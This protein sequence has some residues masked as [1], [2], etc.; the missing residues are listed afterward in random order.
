MKYVYTFSIWPD[1]TWGF[2]RALFDTLRLVNTRVEMTFT[3]AEFEQYRSALNRDGF[4]LRA[5]V[6]VPYREPE[7]VC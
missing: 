2:S 6:R 7:V 4:T 3:E 1:E 5:I